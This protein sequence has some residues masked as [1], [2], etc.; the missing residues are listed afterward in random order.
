MRNASQSTALLVTVLLFLLTLGGGRRSLASDTSHQSA[1]PSA[2]PQSSRQADEYSSIGCLGRRGPNGGLYFDDLSDDIY[3][4]VGNIA[5]L[6]KYVEQQVQIKGIRRSK[7]ITSR[8]PTIEVTDWNAV[9]KQPVAI[10]DSP[11]NS[12]SKWHEYS[13]DTYGVSFTYPYSGR[14][15]RED[16]HL[17]TNFVIQKGTI[18][19]RRSEIPR[20]SYRSPEQQT[21][22]QGLPE[23]NFVGGEFAIFIN[24][25]ITD[26][27]TCYLFLSRGGGPRH[28]D[29][30]SARLSSKTINGV[31]YAESSDV[32]AA[33][34]TSYDHDFFHTFQNGRCYEF[35]F[36]MGLENTGSYNLS[37]MIAIASDDD[38]EALL[39]SKVAFSQPKR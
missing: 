20:D 39:L 4:L 2:T 7:P 1:E 29:R 14:E 28:G 18:T 11:T 16:D 32:G 27:P 30:L 31:T 33:A 23:T 22:T 6:S 26:A 3:H 35:A 12:P 34:G 38:L 17:E 15:T 37:C 9:S 10:L 13:S 19:L 36:I 21:P 8:D 25:E 24:P 5:G